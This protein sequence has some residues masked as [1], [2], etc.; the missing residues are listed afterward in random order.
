MYHKTRPLHSLISKSSGSNQ[1]IFLSQSM[2]WTQC[3]KDSTIHSQIGRYKTNVWSGMDSRIKTRPQIQ[4]YLNVFDLNNWW[5]SIVWCI[6]NSNI[7]FVWFPESSL[8][9]GWILAYRT[10]WYYVFQ[11]K[12]VYTTGGGM[13]HAPHEQLHFC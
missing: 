1:Y 12:S 3:F 7:V 10:L 13:I 11:Y 4:T 2:T 5:Y 9:Q 8:H 6:V